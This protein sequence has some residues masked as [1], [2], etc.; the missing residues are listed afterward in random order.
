MHELD[1]LR[2]TGDIS[3]WAVVATAHAA[4]FENVVEPL[5]SRAVSVPAALS[6]M[7]ER[8]AEA[9]PIAADDKALSAGLHHNR[10]RPA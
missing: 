8:S 4:K 10:K 3:A 7:L 1:R 6:A 9:E 2:D 5:I